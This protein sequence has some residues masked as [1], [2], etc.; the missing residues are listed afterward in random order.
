MSECIRCA[1]KSRVH[2]RSGRQVRQAKWP[3]WG[4]TTHDVAV[5]VSEEGHEGGADVAEARDAVAEH[6][7]GE[8]GVSDEDGQDADDKPQDTG[9]RPPQRQHDVEVGAVVLHVAQD[10]D[11]LQREP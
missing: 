3:T 10:A 7:D 5:E 8:Q 9:G 1:R 11:P 4:A 2:W 6:D